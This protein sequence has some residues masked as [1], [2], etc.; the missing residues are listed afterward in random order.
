MFL[1]LNIT[2]KHIQY[3]YYV[4]QKRLTHSWALTVKV[5]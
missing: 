5:N 1:H 4:I 2:Y 3:V